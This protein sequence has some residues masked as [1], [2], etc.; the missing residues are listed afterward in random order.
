M[1]GTVQESSIVALSVSTSP[2]MSPKATVWPSLTF[3]FTK[4]PTD[5]VSESLGIS[6]ISAI[7]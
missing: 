4:V 7:G 3:H 5:I 2:R 6:I 1:P